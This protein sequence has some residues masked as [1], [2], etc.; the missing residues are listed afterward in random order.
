MAC[1]A[2]ADQVTQPVGFCGISEVSKSNYV[3]NIEG[4]SNFLFGDSAPLTG[5][6]VSLP[7][8][9]LLS[10]PI[11][12]VSGIVTAAPRRVVRPTP[13]VR[14]PFAKAL[15]IAIKVRFS[16]S[17]GSI[18]Q[19]V[20]FSFNFFTAPITFDNDWGHPHR[21]VTSCIFAFF[22]RSRIGLWFWSRAV[23]VF[24]FVS[25][26]ALTRAIFLATNFCLWYVYILAANFALYGDSI[27]CCHTLIL[28]EVAAKVKRNGAGTT[29]LVAMRHN[30]DYIGIDLS[31]E[32][33]EQTLQRFTTLQP[34][35]PGVLT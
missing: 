9:S 19:F 17:G 24:D 2:K 29:G 26:L 5:V 34:M 18:D 27:F 30:R 32:Y 23:H 7:C 12:A 28:P 35:L 4:F 20:G 15:A 31:D 33:F 3:V 22:E 1:M 6:T 11:S 10:Q 14:L 25:A 13:V 16:L 8:L 21:I